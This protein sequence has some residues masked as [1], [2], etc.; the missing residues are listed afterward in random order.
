MP[1]FTDTSSR[2]GT[3]DPDITRHCEGQSDESPEY[4]I[5]NSICD[6][7]P[8]MDSR[9][10]GNRENESIIDQAAMGMVDLCRL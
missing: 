1:S 4:I 2:A 9:F 6:P 7:E 10:R 8:I 5:P 3:R